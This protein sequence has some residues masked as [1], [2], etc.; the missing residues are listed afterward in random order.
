MFS[1]TSR[2]PTRYWGSLPS[3]H[4]RRIVRSPTPRY[5]AASSTETQRREL[6]IT[7]LSG[8]EVSSPARERDLGRMPS[9]HV[10]SNVPVC[11]SQLYMRMPQVITRQSLLAVHDNSCQQRYQGNL[12]YFFGASN[13]FV[14]CRQGP[15]FPLKFACGGEGTQPTSDLGI[16]SSGGVLVDHR[17]TCGAVSEPLHQLRQGRTRLGSQDCAAVA[18]VVPPQ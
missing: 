3:L 13:I 17:C 2:G 12:E 14:I 15:R 7:S 11:C 6:V 10:N 5:A 4:Q 9:Q 16:T 1:R 18:Q 8:I